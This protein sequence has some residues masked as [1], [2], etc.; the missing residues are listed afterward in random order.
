MQIEKIED[1]EQKSQICAEILTVLPEWFGIEESTQEYIKMCKDMDF[2]AAFD[3]QEVKG[4]IALKNH[5]EFTYEIYVCGVQKNCHRKGIGSS[6]FKACEGFCKENNARF[7]TVKTLDES[8]ESEEYAKTRKFYLA[9]GFVPLEVFTELWGKENPCLF[10]CK[11][12]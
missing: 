4:F 11:S 1:K 10:M 9:Q 7:I 2:W 5:N 3:K 6:L 12:I 8:R